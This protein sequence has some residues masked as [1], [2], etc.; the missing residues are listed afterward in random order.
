MILGDVSSPTVV[1]RDQEL[2][3]DVTLKFGDE[4]ITAHKDLIGS[5]IP[6]FNSMFCSGMLEKNQKEITLKIGAEYGLPS[7]DAI[8]AR[9]QN[10]SRLFQEFQ[11]FICSVSIHVPLGTY[12]GQHGLKC[13]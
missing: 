8:K 1:Y 7:T 3:T 9:G 2:F 11:E 6:Y 4:S 10:W 5:S 13:L 12:S